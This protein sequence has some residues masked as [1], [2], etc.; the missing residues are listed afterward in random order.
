LPLTDLVIQRGPVVAPTWGQYRIE[1]VTDVD[2]AGVLG[3][4]PA[5]VLLL[6][7]RGILGLIAGGAAPRIRV[8]TLGERV[9]ETSS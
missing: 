6:V 5:L 8:L 9:G 4:F 2:Y 3:H 7:V 1:R